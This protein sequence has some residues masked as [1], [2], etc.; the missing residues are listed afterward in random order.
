MR[1]E[2]QLRRIRSKREAME[3]LVGSERERVLVVDGE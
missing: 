1:F 2:G 3:G